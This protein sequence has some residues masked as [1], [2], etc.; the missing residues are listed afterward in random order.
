VTN[1]KKL[2]MIC[3]IIISLVFATGVK[4]CDGNKPI[5]Y[6]YVVDVPHQVCSQRKV[7]TFNPLKTEWVQDLPLVECDGA[8]AIHRDDVK[9][10]TRWITDLINEAQKECNKLVEK[11]APQG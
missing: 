2:K 3:L 4:Q 9:K 6:I 10:F 1:G 5:D 8:M 7:I 11:Y